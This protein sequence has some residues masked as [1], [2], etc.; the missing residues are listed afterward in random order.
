MS[1]DIFLQKFAAGVPANANREL[2]QAILETA[3]YTGPD[4]FG[5]YTLN[6]PDGV[7][8]E[9]SAAGLDGIGA[10]AGCAFHIRSM[11]PRLIKFILEI[12]KAGDFV[13]LPAMEDFVPILTSLEQKQ[14][15]P[16]DLAQH[17]PG[18]VVCGS[19]GE[20]EVLLSGGYAGWQEYLSD[21]LEKNRDAG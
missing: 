16:P 10:F 20:L 11:G 13:I 4:K 7:D 6:F 3:E 19:P 9:L 15:L 5:F 12:A 18:P 21:V 8:V 2:V 14:H 1:F 17:S